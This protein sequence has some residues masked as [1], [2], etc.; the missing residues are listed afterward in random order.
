VFGQL[1][2]PANI[3]PIEPGRLRELIVIYGLGYVDVFAVF[4]L[5]YLYALRRRHVLHLTRLDLFDAR[6][7]IEANLIN[8]GTGLGSIA[9]AIRGAAPVVAGLFYFVR[10]P[11]RPIHGARTGRHRR[12]P[13]AALITASP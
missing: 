8:I 1:F 2:D 12:A 6:Y 9:L 3:A 13:E 5:M 7:A 4:L 10:G 11:V